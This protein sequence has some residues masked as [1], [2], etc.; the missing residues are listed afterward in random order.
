MLPPPGM[1]PDSGVNASDGPDVEIGTTI[2][3]PVTDDEEGTGVGKR[4]AFVDSA[5]AVAF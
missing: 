3:E 4:T 5:D 1:G 2:L